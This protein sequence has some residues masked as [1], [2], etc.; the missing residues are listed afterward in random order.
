MAEVQP[1][2]EMSFENI[3]EY[4]FVT[5]LNNLG[6]K[7]NTTVRFFDRG[8]FYTV[9]NDDAIF[10][11]KEL[12]K[13]QS[14]IK[15]LGSGNKKILSVAL[16]KN[17]FE[18]FLRELLLIRQYRVELYRNKTGKSNQWDLV[19]KASPGNLQ[20]FEEMLFG[21]NEMSD[22]AV[23]LSIKV[24]SN[25]NQKLIG[26]AF[27]DLTERILNV[28]EF[29]D[30]DQF[31]NLEAFLLQVGVKECIVTHQDCSDNGGKLQQVLQRSNVLITERKKSE[32]Q[33]KDIHQ[34]LNRLLKTSYGSSNALREVDLLQA[35][36]CLSA[37]IKYL[38]LLSDESVFNQFSIKI[39]DLNQYMRLDA[40]AV[41]ALNVMPSV[42]DGNNKSMS[43]FGLLN[44]CR[45]SQGQRLLAQ[46]VKQPLLDH[47]KIEERLDIVDA[48]FNR[49]D[50][51]KTIQDTYLK[52]MPDL[53]RISKKFSRKKA[54]L[55]DCVRVYQ[56]IKQLPYLLSALDSYEGD[57]KVTIADVFCK[58]L[59]DLISDFSK[60]IELIET[61]VDLEDVENHEYMI[62]AEFDSALQDCK[63]TMNEI[64][65]QLNDSLD[66]AARV[67]GLDAGK[68]I[69]LE[70]NSQIGH[71]FRVTLKEEKVLRSCKKFTTIETRKDGVRFTNSTLSELSNAYRTQKAS[72]NELQTQL[73]NEVIKI[74]SGYADPMNVLSDLVAHLDV[75]LSFSL[76]ASQAP[77]PFVRPKVYPL[78]SDK[79]ILSGSRHPCLEV[80]DDISFIAN[81]VKLVKGEA[82]FLVIT[83]PNMGGKSTYIR[84]IAVITLMAQIGSFVPC[85]QAEIS[86]VK[87][88]MARVGA[89]DSQMKG[90]STFMSE[91]L[92]TA[93]ILNAADKN[94]LII[95]DELGRGTSTYDGFGLAWAISEYIATKVN[96]FCLFATHFHELTTLADEVSTV[97]NFHVTALTTSDRLT[98]LYRVKPGVCDQ[99]FGIHVAEIADFPKHVI[100]F[101]KQ[102]AKELEDFHVYRNGDSDA[103]GEGSTMEDVAKKR[104][105][106]KK[107]SET[108]ISE[109]LMKLKNIPTENRSDEEIIA[110]I[111][112]I[113]KH[114]MLS[115]N[116]Y[117][118]DL[119][120]S[121]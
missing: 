68:T 52:R 64:A 117:V 59:K 103:F 118:I 9:H 102:K 101:A 14:V 5:Y 111:D 109:L 42:D 61:T 16:S 40:G 75:L 73:A 78:G 99:S 84:Q 6:E 45:T 35:M 63:T 47:K 19:G 20:Q 112:L 17:N 62:K 93:S 113:K 41:K 90:V 89:G 95:I 8:E 38:E 13:T 34:D 91:M 25:E 70:S 83:G 15:E 7:P 104:R 85:D 10:A 57:Y 32:F 108:I 110:E 72:Y 105:M 51:R 36:M 77:I 87:S 58:P 48:F 114:A 26:A 24:S 50:T 81:D 21:N 44:M 121:Y 39:F 18:K 1:C 60:Y 28:C 119:L 66:D 94:S 116:P 69:K 76:V 23:I 49:S 106:D 3:G 100:E 115:G 120:D 98:L 4:G 54:S 67:L 46:W 97:K 12:F 82:E 92:E 37:I 33:S 53:T 79:I 29:C 88:I 86:I 31:T 80:Q 71:F 107:A 2:Q 96:A 11:A 65:D 74:A 43:V 55:Q 22:M 30:N 27:V 56:A